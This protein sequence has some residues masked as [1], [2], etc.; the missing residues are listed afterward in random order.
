MTAEQREGL[1]HDLEELQGKYELVYDT[2]VLSAEYLSNQMLQIASVSL[3]K[4]SHDSA[5]DLIIG[6]INKSF[7]L[8]KVVYIQ[9]NNIGFYRYSW[10]ARELQGKT[11]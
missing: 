7:N 2:R 1:Y 4:I 6:A 8:T 10:S 5:M 3:N 11:A 9:K